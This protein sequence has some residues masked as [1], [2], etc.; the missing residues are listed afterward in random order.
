MTWH[1]DPDIGD[2]FSSDGTV[3]GNAGD[4]P[5]S[6]LSMH[7]TPNLLLT[8]CNNVTQCHRK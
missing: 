8:L 4:A 7:L 3:R 5:Y 2:V 6:I 1:L